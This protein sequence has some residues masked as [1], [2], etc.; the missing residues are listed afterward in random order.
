MLSAGQWYVAAPKF[1][2]IKPAYLGVVYVT[3][4]PTTLRC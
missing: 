2:H 1:I 4:E 3:A